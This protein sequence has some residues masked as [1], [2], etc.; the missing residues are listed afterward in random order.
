MGTPVTGKGSVAGAEKWELGKKVCR[1]FAH[2]SAL[3]LGSLVVVVA[4]VLGVCS[5]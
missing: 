4:V 5:D 3:A 2:P 1:I